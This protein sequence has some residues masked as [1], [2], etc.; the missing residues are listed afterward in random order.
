MTEEEWRDREAASSAM[1]L[2]GVLPKLPVREFFPALQTR[3]QVTGNIITLT[4][5][6]ICQICPDGRPS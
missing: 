2:R 4:K 1:P 3:A 6:P 5:L